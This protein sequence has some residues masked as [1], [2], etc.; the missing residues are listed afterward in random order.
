MK[1]LGILHG[2]VRY[3]LHNEN[4]QNL[5]I[6]PSNPQMIWNLPPESFIQ[7]GE[8][9]ISTVKFQAIKINREVGQAVRDK[10][11]SIQLPKLL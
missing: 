11:Q 5:V 3:T 8:R 6:L 9:L 7:I 2:K 10:N 4:P 1:I